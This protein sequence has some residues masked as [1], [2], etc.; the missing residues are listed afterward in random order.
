MSTQVVIATQTD[1]M[2]RAEVA[3]N[4][5]LGDDAPLLEVARARNAFSRK[6]IDAAFYEGARPA[7]NLA[8]R[9]DPGRRDAPPVAATRLPSRRRRRGR[10]LDRPLQASTPGC[11]P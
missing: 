1:T 3:E 9:T 2:N 5:R 8:P 11:C 4:L 7:R 6:A 10:N